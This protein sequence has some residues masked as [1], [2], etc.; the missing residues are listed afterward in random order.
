MV[1]INLTETTHWFYQMLETKLT[2]FY[3]SQHIGRIYL[4]PTWLYIQ[5]TVQTVIRPSHYH[6]NNVKGHRWSST[7][8]KCNRWS[9]TVINCHKRSLKAIIMSH[10]NVPSKCPITNVPSVCR[11]KMSQQN[12]PSKMST[13]FLF[14]F[15]IFNFSTVVLHRDGFGRLWDVLECFSMLFNVLGRFVAVL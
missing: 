12:V 15:S 6:H 14:Y 13:F 1:D 10:Q 11:N 5:E 8:I 7:V 2:Q 3:R 4:Q 9:S